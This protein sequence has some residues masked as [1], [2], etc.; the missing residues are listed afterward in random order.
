[1][2]GNVVDAT[3]TSFENDIKADVPVLVDF[4][5][6]WCGPCR[7][8]GPIV[9]ELANEYEGKA[10]ILKVNVDENSAIAQQFQVMSIPT[11]VFFKDGNKVDELVGAVPKN[12][13][14]EKLKALL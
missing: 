2:A 5:A 1:M 6:E 12:A 4:W 8:I 11:L 3:E 10:K 7:K 14:E 9:E 13:I